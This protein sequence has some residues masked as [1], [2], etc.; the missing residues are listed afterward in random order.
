MWVSELYRRNDKSPYKGIDTCTL[1][2]GYIPR[3]S[4]NNKS[5]YKGNTYI[6]ISMLIYRYIEKYRTVQG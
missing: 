4:R 1:A 3:T 2:R 6:R 5:P